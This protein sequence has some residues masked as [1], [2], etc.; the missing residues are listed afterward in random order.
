MRF[1]RAYVPYGAYWSTPFCKWQGSF[2]PLNAI[3]LAA[4]A[5]SKALALR[6]IDPASLDLSLIHI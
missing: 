6:K 4:D 5:A 3:V 1:T 2:G